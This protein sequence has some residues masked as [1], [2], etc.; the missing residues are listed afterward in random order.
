M[1]NGGRFVASK[2]LRQD[3]LMAIAAD[4]AKFFIYFFIVNKN[5][6]EIF[7]FLIRLTLYKV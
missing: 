2:L 1:R 4:Q 7:I 6:K 3:V 5:L